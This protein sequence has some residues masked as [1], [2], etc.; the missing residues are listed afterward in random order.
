V[1]LGLSTGRGGRQSEEELELDE[2]DVD[3]VVVEDVELDDEESEDFAA[4]PDE[5]EVEAG[6][7]ED[8]VERLS[9]R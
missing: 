4:D 8:V 5:L 6:S 9:L 2:V 3:V 1:P 7:E